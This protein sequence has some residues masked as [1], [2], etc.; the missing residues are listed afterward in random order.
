MRKPKLYTAHN[1]R[2]QNE[3]EGIKQNDCKLIYPESLI[4]RISPGG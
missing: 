2:Y 4:A 1:L 3:I